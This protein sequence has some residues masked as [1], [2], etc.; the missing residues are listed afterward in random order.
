MTSNARAYFY[1]GAFSPEYQ[2]LSPGSV[3]LWYALE[4]AIAQGCHE[5]D[6]LRGAEAYKYSWG[7]KDQRLYP[8]ALTHA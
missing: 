8:L 4:Q 2:R 5:L 1:I 6:F 3:L 7:A